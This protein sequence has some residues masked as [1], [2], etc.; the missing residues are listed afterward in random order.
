MKVMKVLLRIPVTIQRNKR[1]NSKPFTD[2]PK[3]AR[4]FL[5]YDK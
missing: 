1:L 4:L 2:G 3:V 5:P